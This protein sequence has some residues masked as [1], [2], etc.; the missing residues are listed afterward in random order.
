[1]CP[2]TWE[3]YKLNKKGFV[4]K[5]LGMAIM[6]SAIG[7]VLSG[8]LVMTLLSPPFAKM[9]LSF[10]PPSILPSCSWAW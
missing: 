6:C 4:S 2:T 8:V 1:M 9:A 5:A 10:P 7:G 3:G